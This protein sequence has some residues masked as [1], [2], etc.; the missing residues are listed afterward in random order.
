MLE[1]LVWSER[2]CYDGAH[3][4]RKGLVKR[5]CMVR[6][7]NTTEPRIAHEQPYDSSFRALIEDQTLAMLSY[8]ALNEQGCHSPQSSS[9]IISSLGG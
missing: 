4:A 9:H 1:R 3:S 7:R 5:S 2:M 8:L 6:K